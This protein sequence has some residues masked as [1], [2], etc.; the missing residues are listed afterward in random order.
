VWK[1]LQA[2]VSKE[3]HSD[4]SRWLAQGHSL[5]GLVVGTAGTEGVTFGGV[6]AFSRPLADLLLMPKRFLK[7]PLARSIILIL[8][9]ADEVVEVVFFLMEDMTKCFRKN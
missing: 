3:H 6:N 9:F 7:P 2:G 8:G 4:L 5:A 1:P